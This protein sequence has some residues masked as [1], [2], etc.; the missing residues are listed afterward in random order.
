MKTSHRIILL[1]AALLLIFATIALAAEE[2]I[3][4]E[5]EQQETIPTIPK[6]NGN[7]PASQEASTPAT[8]DVKPSEAPSRREMKDLF[9]ELRK[10]QFGNDLF[11]DSD[12]WFGLRSPFFSRNPFGSSLSSKM[13]DD[14]FF[15]SDDD[16]FSSF[17]QMKKRMNNMWRRSLLP[18]LFDDHQWWDDWSN[19][20][21]ANTKKPVENAPESGVVEKPTK[22]GPLSS[23]VRTNVGEKSNEISV[24]ISNI[25]RDVFDKKD[26]EI[27]VQENALGDILTIRGEKKTD[28]GHFEFYKSYRFPKGSVDLDKVKATFNEGK[29]EL[30]L[31]RLDMPPEKEKVKMISIE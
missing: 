21:N 25:P 4:V 10:Y 26:I 1:L 16:F 11:D 20:I 13:F 7:T 19:T 18:S 3:T 30:K 24:E 27:K 31:E 15:G 14:D 12:S 17:N 22:R 2:E 9:K 6:K 8:Q 29:L 5:K 28:T 23:Q